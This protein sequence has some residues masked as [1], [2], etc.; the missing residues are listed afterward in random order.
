MRS[1]HDTT[2]AEID[3][4]EPF[5]PS[6]SRIKLE[7]AAQGYKGPKERERCEVCRYCMCDV[8]NPDTLMERTYLRCAVGQFPVLRGGIC[9]EFK[10]D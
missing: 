5:T 9:R 4:L 3:A 6:R 8:R 7:V 1:P 10:A 2:T